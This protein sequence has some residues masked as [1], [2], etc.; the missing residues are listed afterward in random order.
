MLAR[1]QKKL[2]QFHFPPYQLAVFKTA[3]QRL[4][5]SYQESENTE[6][7]EAS[8]SDYDLIASLEHLMSSLSRHQANTKCLE[9]SLRQL[10]AGFKNSYK[11]TLTL[12]GSN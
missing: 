9:A 1:R 12:L 10:E 3:V 7:K 4:M 6:E 2:R 8:P 5:V 11:D